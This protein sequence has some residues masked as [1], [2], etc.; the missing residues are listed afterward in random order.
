MK[1]GRAGKCQ[2]SVHI[3]DNQMWQVSTAYSLLNVLQS[4]DTSDE[5][6][7]DEIIPFDESRI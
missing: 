4:L 1:I 2:G 5:E 7:A 3:L 6:I